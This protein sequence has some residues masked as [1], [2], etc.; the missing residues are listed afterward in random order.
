[1]WDPAFSGL[2]PDREQSTS[3]DI[4]HYAPLVFEDGNTSNFRN[5][6]L[7]QNLGDLQYTRQK[8]WI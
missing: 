8:H 3:T 2:V 1:M 6:F 7:A 5:V 4:S